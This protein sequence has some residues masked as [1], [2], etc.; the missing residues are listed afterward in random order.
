M[1]LDVRAASEVLP[2]DP[3]PCTGNDCEDA[4]ESE[5]GTGTPTVTGTETVFGDLCADFGCS[6]T[7]TTRII[8]ILCLTDS[9]G[10]YGC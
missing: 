7:P 4:T 5:T 9:C 3:T 8:Y 2:E 1:S 6:L 10:P